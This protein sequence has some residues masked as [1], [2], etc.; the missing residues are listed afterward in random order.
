MDVPVAWG[1]Q[2]AARLDI[3]ALRFMELR[4]PSAL[5]LPA[6]AHDRPTL[7]VVMR[8]GFE[9]RL[10][11]DVLECGRASLRVEPAG[12]TH[13]NRFG[14]AGAH[15]VVVQ[16]DPASPLIAPAREAL[17]RADHRRDERAERI[18]RGIAS[19]LRHRDTVSPLALQS[20]GLELVA[21]LARSGRPSRGAPPFVARATELI[22]DRF[23]EGL[24]IETIAAA[25]DAS[26]NE[27]VRAFRA[28]H[29]VPIGTYT[30]RLRLE[31]VA[32]RL[33][34]TDEPVASIA[35]DAGFA[36]QPHLTR[37]FRAYTGLT[38]ARYRRD[39]AL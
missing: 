11:S 27:L 20:L 4:F 21:A 6:H 34:G 14:P 9:T 3:G 15:I 39:R 19:E 35:H 24:R 28:F 37:A 17:A 18:G 32:R 8:G 31:W 16:P 26:P 5:V 1:S 23:L 7:A 30:R 38:P 29:G 13:S 2:S 25:V 33:T 12:S 22:H 10:A 36:D